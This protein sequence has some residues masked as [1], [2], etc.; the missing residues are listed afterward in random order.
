MSINYLFKNYS[1]TGGDTRLPV[2]IQDHNLHL[3]ESYWLK[4]SQAWMSV[5]SRHMSP[6]Y[7]ALSE[8]SP[9]H[10][11]LAG[12]RI[13]SQGHPPQSHPCI[14][15]MTQIYTG[16]QYLHAN[17][18]RYR[19]AIDARSQN[20]TVHILLTDLSVLHQEL[21]KNQPGPMSL[22]F[23]IANMFPMNSCLLNSPPLLKTGPGSYRQFWNF[24]LIQ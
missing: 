14:S 13:H 12:A 7:W 9:T 22:V 18:Q 17:R 23:K 8:H 16:T 2:I 15:S 20:R 21:L 1:F 3:F 5:I 4:Q 11:D 19:S 24:Q 10:C 6:I